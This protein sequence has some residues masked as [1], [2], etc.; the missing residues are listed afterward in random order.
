MSFFTSHKTFKT[1]LSLP[2]FKHLDSSN[3]VNLE[4]C[5]QN[6]TCFMHL[7]C[8]NLLCTIIARSPVILQFR[9]KFFEPKTVS[10]VIRKQVEICGLAP[11][12]ID[13]FS[14]DQCK[15]R[16]DVRRRLRALS[17]EKSSIN[18]DPLR[19]VK[20]IFLL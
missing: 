15:S 13:K 6:Q 19:C 1:T 9:S 12:K 4:Q 5:T 3:V 18:A 16:D 17:C 7:F 20:L 8:T 14:K 2:Q 10:S 11:N